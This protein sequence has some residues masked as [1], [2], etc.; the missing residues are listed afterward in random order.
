M[1]DGIFQ[2][3][4][5]NKQ[6]MKQML[7]RKINDSMKVSSKHVVFWNNEL[8]T[9]FRLTPVTEQKIEECV[10]VLKGGSA[11]GMDE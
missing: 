6:F 7:V 4:G 11:P 2:T 1:D 9:E 8:K 3:T 10:A 5:M